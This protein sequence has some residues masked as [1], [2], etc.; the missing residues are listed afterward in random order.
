M[1]DQ[2]RPL[3]VLCDDHLPEHPVPTGWRGRQGFALPDAPWDLADRRWMCIG[4]IDGPE[5]AGRAIEALSRGVGLAVAVRVEGDL[6][7]R[8]LEDLHRLGEVRPGADG[9]DLAALLD[10][11]QLALLGALAA[12]ATVGAA[13]EAVHLS[14]RTANRRLAELRA[15][16]GVDSNAEAI[17][18][19]VAQRRSDDGH[20]SS[21]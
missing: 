9:D 10:P 5:D 17:G 4:T 1:A 21:R 18:R 12:G 11:D 20:G 16:L 14:R 7:H 2:A 15:R 13:A 3:V 8:T 6:R 19:W